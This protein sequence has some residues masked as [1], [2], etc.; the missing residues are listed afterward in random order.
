MISILYLESKNVIL[1]YLDSLKFNKKDFLI[2]AILFLSI[3]AV[4]KFLEVFDVNLN[5]IQLFILL[6]YILSAFVGSKD[7]LKDY[8]KSHSFTLNYIYP[9]SKF[10]LFLIKIFKFEIIDIFDYSIISSLLILILYLAGYSFSKAFIGILCITLCSLSLKTICSFFTFNIIKNIIGIKVL[11]ETIKLFLLFYYFHYLFNFFNLIYENGKINFNKIFNIFR[12]DISLIDISIFNFSNSFFTLKT[13]IVLFFCYLVFI[14]F[15]ILIYSKTLVTLSVKQNQSS[16]ISLYF[17]RNISILK[18]VRALGEINFWT[19]L[20]SK[21]ISLLL[22]LLLAKFLVLEF[23]ISFTVLLIIAFIECT[24]ISDKITKSYIA[25]EKHF[26]LN[27]LFSNTSLLD[28]LKKRTLLYSFFTL[29]YWIIYVAILFFVFN[30]SYLSY[31][32]MLGLLIIS[33]PIL[34]FTNDSLNTFKAS[35]INELGIPNT[36]M[37]LMKILIKLLISYIFL[38]SITFFPYIFNESFLAT[39]ALMS[40]TNWLIFFLLYKILTKKEKEL[41]GEYKTFFEN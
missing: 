34:I 27:Y 5:Y 38:F 17:I 25:K 7:W 28:V 18:E 31:F 33:Q 4:F 30:L 2:S 13:M 11:L 22:F 16:T 32:I 12:I 3:L 21:I 40:F 1:Q 23:N 26:V 35:Y 6:I 41:Y 24:N 20:L 29:P 37:N 14:F 8:F 36:K 15:K 9:L 39:I 19:F 10:K